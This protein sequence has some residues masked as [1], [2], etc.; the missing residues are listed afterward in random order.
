MVSSCWNGDTEPIYQYNMRTWHVSPICAENESNAKPEIRLGSIFHIRAEA[1]SRPPRDTM[2]GIFHDG[3]KYVLLREYLGYWLVVSTPLKNLK[4]SWDD[5]IPNIWKVIKFMF[6]TTLNRVWFRGLAVPSKESCLFLSESWP[7]HD[8]CF[9]AVLKCGNK[10]E[11]ARI[12]TQH[13]WHGDI[14]KH[15]PWECNWNQKTYQI[16]EVAER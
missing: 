13:I 9:S 7:T 15:L 14:Q 8:G 4:V 1:N 6:Q 2:M 5:D 10:K 11:V 16:L 3:S 12:E